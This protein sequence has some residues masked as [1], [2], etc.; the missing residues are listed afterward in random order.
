MIKYIALILSALTLWCFAWFFYVHPNNTP[1]VVDTPQINLMRTQIEDVFKR[2]QAEHDS[3][4][5]AIETL[6]S[7]VKAQKTEQRID[8]LPGKKSLPG[9]RPPN[10]VVKFDLGAKDPFIIAPKEIR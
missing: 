10:G 9:K 3:L 8:L 4:F 7:D 5:I 6:R 2:L 1:I